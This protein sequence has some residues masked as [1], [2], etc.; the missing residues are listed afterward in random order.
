MRATIIVVAVVLLLS[1]LVPSSSNGGCCYVAPPF[2]C[3][4][5][6]PMIN[7]WCVQPAEPTHYCQANGTMCVDAGN[8]CCCHYL[9]PIF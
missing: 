4:R 5:M 3:G 2:F 7:N 6:C 9:A 1:V 8:P